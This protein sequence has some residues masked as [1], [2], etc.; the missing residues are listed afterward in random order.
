MST[1]S[2][3]SSPLYVV[4]GYKVNQVINPGKSEIWA[5]LVW[6]QDLAWLEKN[7]K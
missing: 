7:T 1:S 6:R 5:P 3:I 2:Q 4:S